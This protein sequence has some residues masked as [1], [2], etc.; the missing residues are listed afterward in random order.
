LMA[1]FYSIVDQLVTPSLNIFVQVWDSLFPCVFNRVIF[2]LFFF[3]WRNCVTPIRCSTHT[4]IST[5]VS[6]KL[7]THTGSAAMFQGVPKYRCNAGYDLVRSL[8]R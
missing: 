7:L 8:A 4:Q 6:L 1:I 3:R 2:F 5:L